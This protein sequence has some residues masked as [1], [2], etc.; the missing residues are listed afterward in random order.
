MRRPEE[1]KQN[2]P[3][4]QWGSD[5]NT[6]QPSTSN[7]DFEIVRSSNPSVND[8]MPYL[9]N[10]KTGEVSTPSGIIKPGDPGYDKYNTGFTASKSTTQSNN[11]ISSGTTSN[12]RKGNNGNTLEET[13]TGEKLIR[14]K[15]GKLIQ[16]L[17]KDGTSKWSAS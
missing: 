9:V 8:G 4:Y 1:S 6:F 5:D 17:N 7:N 14:D 10:K 3:T 13:S 2:I 16:I 15:N 11:T 12:I